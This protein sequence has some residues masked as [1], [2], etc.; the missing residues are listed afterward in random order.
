MSGA[1]AKHLNLLEGLGTIYGGCS[2]G[3]GGGGGGGGDG[4]D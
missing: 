2:C 3:G 4:C 1:C